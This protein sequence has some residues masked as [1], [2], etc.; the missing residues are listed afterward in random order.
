MAFRV[1]AAVASD[2][3][4]VIDA[5]A[6]LGLHIGVV[7]QLLNDLQDVGPDAAVRK[8]DIRRG[9]RTLP[10]AYAL[11]NARDEGLGDILHW[12]ARQASLSA[13]D[14]QR[15]VERMHDLG[16]HQYTW[17]VAQAHR[18]EALAALRAL[19]SA[20]N[21]PTVRRLRHLIP[22]IAA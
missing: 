19:S 17:T 9:K 20:S 18:H 16:A 12:I 13:E 11:Q 10:I 7:A 15:L 1:G 6:R 21:R 14:E 5:A 3:D 8:G 22:R 2:D 4:D